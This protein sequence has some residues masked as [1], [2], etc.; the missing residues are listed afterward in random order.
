MCIT[1]SSST[2]FRRF[3]LLAVLTFWRHP[4]AS[5][6]RAAG[7]RQR[8]LNPLETITFKCFR[9]EEVEEVEVD[10]ENSS[11]NTSGHLFTKEMN[12]Y[13]SNGTVQ[14]IEVRPS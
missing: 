9:S 12:Q 10:P 1:P 4:F 7:R 2:I 14:N 5:A 6:V 13:T 8:W 11:E 3:Q